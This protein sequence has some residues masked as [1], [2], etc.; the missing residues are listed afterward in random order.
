M[1]SHIVYER[2]G[3]FLTADR[4]GMAFDLEHAGRWSEAEAKAIV[5]TEKRRDLI[6]SPAVAHSG[7]A[8][9]ELD[10]H[11]QRAAHLRAFLAEIGALV[12]A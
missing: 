8:L 10:Q 12:S 6:A 2:G 3:G 9:A 4:R 11:E 7:E 1:S 5:A